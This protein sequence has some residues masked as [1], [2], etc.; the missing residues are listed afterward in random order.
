MIRY[1]LKLAAA[2]LRR[3]RTVTLPYFLANTLTILLYYLVLNLMLNPNVANLPGGSILDFIFSLGVVVISIFSA[4][5][6]IS[7]SQML[8][9]R[10]KKELGLYTVL[11]LEKK[12]IAL[13]VF[14]ENGLQILAALV[15]SIG[16]GIIGG[17][18]IW[19]LL[20]RILETPE[21]LP[22]VFSFQA[23]S[24]TVLLFS[25]LFLI[26]TIS[27]LIQIHFI[28]PIDLL[29]GEEKADRPVRFLIP[30]TILGGL[31]LIVAYAVAVTA[32][33]PFSA[34][35]IFFF[36]ALIVIFA[37][38]LLFEA[39]TT[40]LLGWLKKRKRFYYQPRNF[41][42]VS[43]LM[44]RI[45]RNASSLA[46][47]CILST[48]LL[49]TLGGSVA[50][51]FGEHN[52]LA[53]SNPDDL[54]YTL[55]QE[56]TG[57]QRWEIQTA[58]EELADK[59]NVELEDIQVYSYGSSYIKLID[60]VISSFT[61][62]DNRAALTSNILMSGRDLAVI[63][64]DTYLEI[65]GKHAGL[66]NNEVLLLSSRD[67]LPSTSLKLGSLDFTVNGVLHDTPFT[68]RKYRNGAGTNNSQSDD[69]IFLVV[70]DEAT[71][72]E[73]QSILEPYDWSF[74]TRIGADYSGNSQKRTNFYEEFNQVVRGQ[75]IKVTY[76]TCLDYDRLEFRSMYGGLLFIGCFFSVLFL[77][78]TVLIIYFKQISEAAEDRGQYII[79]QKVGM[80]KNEV[81]AAINRQ[82]AI[83]FF[84]PLGTALLHTAFSIPLIQILLVVLKL[85]DPIYTY[86]SVSVC[87]LVFAVFYLLFFRMTSQVVKREVAFQV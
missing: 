71:L 80:D 37:T 56:L 5:F 23:I 29:H 41:I 13:I 19:M 34:I 66:E 4:V 2:N 67:D 63:R 49:V 62:E 60:G 76:A 47:I 30:K 21:A 3:S 51:N 45:R 8:L 15:F 79:L 87:A 28:N 1:T 48:M 16:L 6:M 17:R 85:T 70:A 42:A 65:T 32:N 83:V 26:T 39:G 57:P 54:T 10:R 84:L 64:Q 68:Q 25:V 59:H 40:F 74:Y 86:A 78:A 14:W 69:M 9:K 7:I 73:I 82:V 27:S 55:D 33:N 77:T 36:D 18:L 52:I 12:H 20:L 43:M 58:A 38:Y 53:E 22:Y 44:H 11:G 75:G 24:A 81:S 61:A 46:T 72:V 31:C 35:M 50:L